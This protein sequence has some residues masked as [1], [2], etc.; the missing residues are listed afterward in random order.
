MK[1]TRQLIPDKARRL[2]RQI[3]FTHVRPRVRAVLRVRTDVR[4]GSRGSPA[5]KSSGGPRSREFPYPSFLPATVACEHRSRFSVAKFVRANDRA[6]ETRPRSERIG[7]AP[8]QFQNAKINRRGSPGP[9][10]RCVKN[11]ALVGSAVRERSIAGLG[12]KC[13]N[14][15]ER[16]RSRCVI[17]NTIETAIP[18]GKA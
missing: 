13:R 15:W 10:C 11:S 8:V 5:I 12:G 17:N 9:V 1:I 7:T 2:F 18:R 6:R 14:H 16:S 4:R 3:V